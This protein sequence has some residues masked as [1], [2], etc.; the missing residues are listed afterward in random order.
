MK[1]ET[2]LKV[3]PFAPL[4]NEQLIA[5]LETLLDAALAGDLQGMA[6]VLQFNRKN[7]GNGWIGVDSISIIAEIEALKFEL[8]MAYMEMREDKHQ[9]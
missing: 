8:M 5:T 7:T 6:Y 1:R 3:I 9:H 4:L 2:D